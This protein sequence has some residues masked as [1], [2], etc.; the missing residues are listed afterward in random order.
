MPQ[1]DPK[2]TIRRRFRRQ[3]LWA[4]VVFIACMLPVGLMLRGIDRGTQPQTL[5][6]VMLLTALTIYVMFNLYINA[7]RCTRCQVR[8]GMFDDRFSA[9]DRYWLAGRRREFCPNCLVSFDERCG[10]DGEE[11]THAPAGR[12]EAESWQQPLQHLGLFV[13]LCLIYSSYL[14]DLL[15]SRDAAPVPLTFGMILKFLLCT[16][17]PFAVIAYIDDRWRALDCA[18]AM[19]AAFVVCIVIWFYK[20]GVTCSRAPPIFFTLFFVSAALSHRIG[21]WHHPFRCEI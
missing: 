3:F 15:D 10:G 8:I 7:V 21:T 5:F 6:G 12:G 4:L 9:G 18:R 2:D 17:W 14:R 1:V 20:Y 19:S 11:S 13:V 16:G